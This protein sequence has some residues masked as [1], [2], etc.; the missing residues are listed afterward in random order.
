V[1]DYVISRVTL[2]IILLQSTPFQP[3]KSSINGFF[4]S[5]EGIWNKLWKSLADFITG[6][7]CRYLL[8]FIYIYIY[9]YV[10]QALVLEGKQK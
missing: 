1:A 7:T 6:K 2:I 8:F 4:E 10:L 9:I 3:P 5:I